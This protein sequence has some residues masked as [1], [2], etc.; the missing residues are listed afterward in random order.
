MADPQT[1][2]RDTAVIRKEIAQAE[3]AIKNVSEQ[4]KTQQQ[5]VAGLRFDLKMAMEKKYA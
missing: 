5:R 4:L 3:A 2:S 1:T